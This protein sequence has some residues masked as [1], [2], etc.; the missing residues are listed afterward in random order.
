MQRIEKTKKRPYSVNL[1]GVT[2]HS[3]RFF[4]ITEQKR[5]IFDNYFARFTLKAFHI[6]NNSG[7]FLLPSKNALIILFTLAR[8]LLNCASQAHQRV[9]FEQGERSITIIV[10]LGLP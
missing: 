5:S 9:F 2:T 4:F 3:I 6:W 7:F 10:S 1:N 8:Q